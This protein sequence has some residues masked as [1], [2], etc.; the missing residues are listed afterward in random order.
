MH[1][2]FL[3]QLA[4]APGRGVKGVTYGACWNLE[5]GVSFIPYSMVK[6]EK[7]LVDLAEG[8]WVDPMTCP[9]GMSVPV[10]GKCPSVCACVCA[11]KLTA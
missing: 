2:M 9:P 7:D 10:V 11:E 8:G 4:W 6:K 1:T 5:E 3:L